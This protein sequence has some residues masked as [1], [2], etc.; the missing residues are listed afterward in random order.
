MPLIRITC[1]PPRTNSASWRGGH[2]TVWEYIW[3]NVSHSISAHCDTYGIFQTNNIGCEVV[4]YFFHFSN[5]DYNN[6]K[7]YELE[8]HFTVP[9]ILPSI[10]EQ[11][12]HM[13]HGL[14]QFIHT[15]KRK[16]CQCSIFGV[17]TK[18]L[19]WTRLSVYNEIYAVFKKT[20]MFGFS[21]HEK[22]P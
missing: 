7:A 13:F 20:R 21:I 12:I 17:I 1:P 4:C 10:T 16:A 22:F 11:L 15:C 18:T 2:P 6:N 3:P 14:F 8:V 19:F 5:C 9:F